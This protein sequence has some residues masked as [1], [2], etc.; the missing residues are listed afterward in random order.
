MCGY[1]GDPNYYYPLAMQ[2][3][4][5]R[6]E[7]EEKSIKIGMDIKKLID[8]ENNQIGIQK[9]IMAEQYRQNIIINNS[10][11]DAMNRSYIPI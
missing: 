9:E 3:D 4:E 8:D 1:Y 2:M 7:D 5:Y 11:M 10:I 6:R